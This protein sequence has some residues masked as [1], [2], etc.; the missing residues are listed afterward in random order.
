MDKPVPDAH[1]RLMALGF[2]FRDRSLPRRKVLD[3]VDIKPGFH[4][5]DYG[6]GPGSYSLTAAEMV[7]NSGRV[8][9]L[10]IHPLAIRM[11]RDKAARKG[12][13]NLVTIH[14]DCATGLP[15]ESID[16][17]LLYDIFHDLSRPDKILV[18][19]GWI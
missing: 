7:G 3:E 1:F 13:T 4:I 15:D 9:A 10:D 19:V 5:L 16:V 2:K 6:C 18:E 14:S 11:V 17:A 12:L 8:Y